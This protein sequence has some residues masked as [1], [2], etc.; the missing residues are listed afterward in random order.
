MTKPDAV[1]MVFIA[2]PLDRVWA[3][4]V[5]Q[6]ASP[7]FFFGNTM[8]V[9]AGVGD[10]FQVRG[11]DGVLQVE[12][13]VLA[14]EAPRRLRVSWTVAAFPGLPASEFD[15]LL[16]QVGEVVRLTVSEFNAAPVEDKFREAGRD[17]WSLILS[18]L[19]TLLETGAPMP[20]ATPKAPQ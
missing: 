14:R 5:D 17:G 3:T 9:G 2:A 19:K 8:T 13:R 6:A 15:F 10:A 4:L 7:G 12:G 1:Y 16:E 20:P 18:S 11:P